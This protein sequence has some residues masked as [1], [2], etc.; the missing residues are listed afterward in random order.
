MNDMRLLFAALF[1]LPLYTVAQDC[2]ILRDTDPYT[3]ET[4]ISSGFIALQGG[5]LTIDADSRE[6]D[7]FFVV[8]GKCF[9]D[10]STVFVYFEGTK[11]KATYRAASSMNC[12]GYFHFTFRNSATTTPFPVQKFGTQKVTQFIFTD[13]DKKQVVVSVQPDQ[14]QIFMDASNCIA[15]EAKKLI[16]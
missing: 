1:F 5:T 4:K 7:Y 13:S 8:P 3:K 9:N 14:Q 6:I 2:K 15:A 10:Q 12:E 16:K 11:S